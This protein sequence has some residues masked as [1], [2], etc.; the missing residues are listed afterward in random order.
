MI[1]VYYVSCISNQCSMSNQGLFVSVPPFYVGGGVFRLFG[2]GVRKLF[3]WLF[4]FYH[5]AGRFCRFAVEG[6]VLCLFTSLIVLDNYGG[7]PTCGSD[8]LSPRRQTRSLLRRLA[9]RR[10]ITLVV[11]G[12]GPIRELNV[13][14]CG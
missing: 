12:S 14:P 10:G 5:M 13:G 3:S 2:R 4:C 6:G 9:L 1:V 8:D 11:S 7:R